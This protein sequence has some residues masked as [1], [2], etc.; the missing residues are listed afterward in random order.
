MK[1]MTKSRGAR[2]TAALLGSLTIGAMALTGCSAQNTET[3]DNGI[4]PM[5]LTL[6]HAYAVDSLQNK[7]AEQLAE[8]VSELSD[9]AVTIEVFPSAQLGSWE[10]MQEGLEIGSVDIVIESLG[11]LERYTDLAAIE[12]LPFLY[13]DAEHFFEVWDGDMADEILTA[14]REDSGFQL[15]GA[16]YRGGRQLNS[17]RPVEELSQLNGLKLRVPNQQ[18]YINT[19]QALG[20]SPTPMA[21]NEVF[22]AMEQ[23]A[24]EG[25]ENPIDVV[26][27]SSFYEV[28]KYVTETNHLFGNFHFQLWGDTYDAWPTEVRDIFDE[29]SEDVSATYREASIQGAIDDKA[30]LEENGVEFY[31]IDVADW[32]KPVSDLIE[33]AD[34]TVRDWAEE[35]QSLR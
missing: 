14:V 17:I 9:G 34:P 5:A 12:G 32:R 33:Q 4:E 28:A 20:A 6:G 7:A 13:E 23:G 21:L 2:R 3:G 19:W 22:S 8:R 35:I 10:E 11:S 30:F 31:E 15:T 27:Y 26:R 29:A 16:L 1:S 25:Q 24:V 18:T